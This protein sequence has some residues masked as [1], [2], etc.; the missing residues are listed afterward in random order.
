MYLYTNSKKVSETV[1]DMADEWEGGYQAPRG[2]AIQ[3]RKA[4]AVHKWFVDN[5]QDGNDDCGS[6]VV[7]VDDLV[8]LHDVCQEVLDNSKLID[9]DVTNGYTFEDGEKVPIVEK[10]QY[11]EDPS[12][13]KELLPTTGGFF[14]GSTEYDQWYWWDIQF[15]ERKLAVLLDCLEPKELRVVHKDEPDWFVEFRYTSSW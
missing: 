4:N 5:V 13:A 10:G 9:G 14:F 15:T 12:V 8:K 11:I 1:N 6:Y 3:W 7:T 2:I